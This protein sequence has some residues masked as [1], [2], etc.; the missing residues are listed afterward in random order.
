MQSWTELELQ[1]H[2]VLDR[3]LAQGYIEDTGNYW[4]RSPHGAVYRQAVGF[5]LCRLD[6][7]GSRGAAQGKG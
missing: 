4:Y 5:Q 6:C 7:F 1:F 2:A 3:L